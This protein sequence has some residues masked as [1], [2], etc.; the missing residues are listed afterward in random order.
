[1]RRAMRRLPE[2]DR[3]PDLPAWKL[4]HFLEL[5]PRR[6]DGERTLATGRC[7]QC[8]ARAEE[9]CLRPRDV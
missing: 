8:D 5:A 7:I 9:P 1:M 3:I 4:D 6:C 2:H